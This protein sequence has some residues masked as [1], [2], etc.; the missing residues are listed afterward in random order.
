MGND[1]SPG[2]SL[3][4]NDAYGLS[5][6]RTQTKQNHNTLST[7]ANLS[8][9]SYT[10]YSPPPSHINNKPKHMTTS[11][12][13]TP[14]NNKRSYQST[15]SQIERPIS[16]F[17]KVI[18]VENDKGYRIEIPISTLEE[19]GLTCGWLVSETI[20][21]FTE[22]N[23]KYGYNQ[24]VSNIFKL[25]TR[26]K[27]YT[28]DYW[29]S[30]FERSV[31]ALKDK[32]VLQPFYGDPNYKVTN[33]KIGLN[34]F[35][36]LKLIGCGGFSKV[37]LA[38]RKDNG[39]LYA[40]KVISKKEMIQ[41]DKEESVF[42]ER[43]LMTRLD[44]PF[45]VKL[46]FSF[47]SKKNLYLVMDFMPGGELFYNFRRRGRLSEDD[48]KIY[49]GQ[50]IL[51]LNYLHK[52]NILFRDLKPEN[53]LLDLDGHLHLADFGLCKTVQNKTLL[54]YSFCGSP[55]YMAPEMVT[56]TGYNFTLDYYCLGALVYE[57][58]TG[59]PPFYAEDRNT[60]FENIALKDVYLPS[61]IS[62]NLRSFLI[63]L[64][65]KSPK[66]RLGANQG[67]TEIIN[68]PW[69]QNI[70]FAKLILKKFQAPIVPEL[71]KLNFEDE[72]LTSLI[73]DLD[74]DEGNPHIKTMRSVDQSP[75]LYQKFANFSFYSNI[76][77]DHSQEKYLDPIFHSPRSLTEVGSATYS[78]N[79][80]SL[81]EYFRT[82]RKFNSKAAS[83]AMALRTGTEESTPQNKSFMVYST[84]PI[85]GHVPD[86]RTTT[87]S[88]TKRDYAKRASLQLDF[89]NPHNYPQ[90]ASTNQ[91]V[92][93]ID[94]PGLPEN[95]ARLNNFE[96]TSGMKAF[97]MTEY[98][99]SNSDSNN[100]LNKS[101][102]TNYHTNYIPE[103]NK[104]TNMSARQPVSLRLLKADLF[105]PQKIPATQ[106]IK[107]KFCHEE[108]MD[109]IGEKSPQTVKSS[110]LGTSTFS[111]TMDRFHANVKP[112]T[113][114]SKNIRPVPSPI[115]NGQSIKNNSNNIHKPVA[116]PQA[117]VKVRQK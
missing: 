8:A 91:T 18:Y 33:Q 77:D 10:P 108:I 37:Y 67:L 53:I 69:C 36:I 2:R 66:T 116:K 14:N 93:S 75:M 79:T 64:L 4:Y 27:L 7:S 3:N 73:V 115:Y 68:H 104:T 22:V 85:T 42:N 16:S 35:E 94:S 56:R 26:D 24:V 99:N 92:I 32:I 96:Q 63:K 54:N 45:L 111:A 84:P 95:S 57:L 20:R 60:L 61:H 29:L 1:V 82:A 97:T 49:A 89:E 74:D 28:V 9:S 58:V 103:I 11:T 87:Y 44:H 109:V 72:F 106:E 59:C 6:A 40:I 112:T 52:N 39:M 25:Q 90:I 46:H 65:D 23:N 105:S 17:L 30:N 15:T 19:S 47:Q 51:C 88:A 113:M 83:S 12:I 86:R 13:S 70:N 34:Y 81:E 41:K 100:K 71:N 76:A 98:Y 43:N 62:P 117:N 101:Y 5:A 80:Q 31:A 21:R 114:N 48:A 38:R 110:N 55:E 107:P 78:K 102:V 50:I